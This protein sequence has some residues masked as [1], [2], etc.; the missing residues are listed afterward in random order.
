MIADELNPLTEAVDFVLGG[1]DD[2]RDG[3]SF[4]ESSVAMIVFRSLDGSLGAE[5]LPMPNK[6]AAGFFGLVDA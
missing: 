1:D 4:S 2:E 6:D 5:D 3:F